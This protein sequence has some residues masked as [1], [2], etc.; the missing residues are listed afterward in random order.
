MTALALELCPELG[1]AIPVG[2]DSLSMQT[3]WEAEGRPEPLPRPY[4]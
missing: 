2:K 3:R 1:I 4:P